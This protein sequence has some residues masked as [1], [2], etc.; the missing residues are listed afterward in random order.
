[1]SAPKRGRKS[2]EQ[3]QADAEALHATLVEQV[4]TLTTTEGWKR[5]LKVAATFHTYSLNNLMLI[6]A[7]N[8]DATDVAGF[9]Q[10]QQRGRQVR[11]GERGIKIRGYSTKR[12]TVENT[13][14]GEEEEKRLARFPILTVFDVDQTDPIEGAEQIAAPVQLLTG[15]DE[16]GITTAVTHWLDSQGWTLTREQVGGGA[17]GYTT[18]DGTRR[19]VVREDLEPAAAA[20][21]SLHEAGHVILHADDP[22]GEYVAHRG[23]KE[24]EAES[25]AYVMGGL[26]G[27]DTTAYS[28]GYIAT[29]AEGDVD[30]VRAAAENVLRAVHTLAEALT[31]TDLHQEAAA[32]PQSA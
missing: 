17:N 20:K 2:P 7:Q 12:V 4:E 11:K 1:M 10:W 3:R 5:F 28:V 14:T 6:V 32:A 9:R 15:D 13:E 27:L 31:A 8:P 29:W 24:T 18:T 25:V 16:H 23:R 30:L 26:L 21:T 22:A 19:V